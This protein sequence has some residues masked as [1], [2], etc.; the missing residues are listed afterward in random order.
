[1]LIAADEKH[2]ST[3]AK[4]ILAALSHWTILRGVR[5]DRSSILGKSKWLTTRTEDS[6]HRRALEETFR[7]LRKRLRCGDLLQRDDWRTEYS[8]ARSSQRETHGKQTPF[9]QHPHRG[10]SGRWCGGRDRCSVAQIVLIAELL[11]GHWWSCPTGR[12][13]RG[14]RRRGG[15][16]RRGS[17]TLSQHA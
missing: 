16:R 11:F 7:N 17:L 6:S 12:D 4:D 14:A 8:K 5:P 9:A 3:C 15:R 2:R 1:M 10:R 13:R